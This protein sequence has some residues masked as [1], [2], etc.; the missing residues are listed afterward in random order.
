MIERTKYF[1]D[2]L[3]KLIS[4][5]LI[6]VNEAR[7]S[8][9]NLITILERN[10][11]MLIRTAV[12]RRRENMPDELVVPAID[13]IADSPAD[14]KLIILMDNAKKFRGSTGVPP[15]PMKELVV[16]CSDFTRVK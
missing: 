11:R 4:K 6:N 2:E 14:A 8:L 13:I 15:T 7:E 5:D 16:V 12:L 9:N 3:K 10:Q 1:C